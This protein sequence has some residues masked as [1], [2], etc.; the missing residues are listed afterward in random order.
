[1]H[2]HDRDA[3]GTMRVKHEKSFELFVTDSEITGAK[4]GDLRV[5]DGRSFQS[6]GKGRSRFEFDRDLNAVDFDRSCRI[7]GIEFQLAL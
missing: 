6:Q 5:P 1:M 2:E 4:A 7:R 3:S